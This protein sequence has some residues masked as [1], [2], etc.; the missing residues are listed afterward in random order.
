MLYDARRLMTLSPGWHSGIE[1]SAAAAE[2]IRTWLPIA[3]AD[4]TMK[5]Q[6]EPEIVGNGLKD[7]QGAVDKLRKGVSATKLVV[8]IA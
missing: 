8:E 5:C 6:P 7:V 3:L 2:L 4:G 1:A